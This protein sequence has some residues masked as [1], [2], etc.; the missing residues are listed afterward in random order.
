MIDKPQWKPAKGY[1]YLKDVSVGELVDTS[2][3]LRAIV[4]EHTGCATQVIVL[5]ADH[6]PINERA[7]YL[8]DQRWSESTEVKVI[9]E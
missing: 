7:F 4:V 8:G 2:S 9:G 5:R 1:K 6:H 3:G